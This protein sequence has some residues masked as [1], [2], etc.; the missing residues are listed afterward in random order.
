MFC[1]VCLVTRDVRS[2]QWFIVGFVLFRCVQGIRASPAGRRKRP[3]RVRTC[4]LVQNTRQPKQTKLSEGVRTHPFRSQIWVQM[5][6]PGQPTRPIVPP[7]CPPR[8]QPTEA[9]SHYPP[10]SAMFPCCTCSSSFSSL[11]LPRPP[12]ASACCPRPPEKKPLLPTHPD[13]ALDRRRP[14]FDDH[15]RV[16]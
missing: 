4:S 3:T 12:P 11:A 9:P 8:A 5:R 15:S 13:A 7:P 14:P 16:G 1:L 6:R 2:R 10:S